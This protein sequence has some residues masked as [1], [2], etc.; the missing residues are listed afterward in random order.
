VGNKREPLDDE[1]TPEEQRLLKRSMLVV[2]GGELLVDEGTIWADGLD[3]MLGIST[4]DVDSMFG[5]L[6]GC[7][8]GKKADIVE[9]TIMPRNSADSST[10]ALVGVSN[11]VPFDRLS[12]S[13]LLSPAY[14]GRLHELSRE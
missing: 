3:D 11:V 9:L 6:I 13:P 2:P 14:A 12:S 7:L 8:S 4:R 5:L 1:R 10:P